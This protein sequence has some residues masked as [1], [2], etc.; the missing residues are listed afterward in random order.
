MT[1]ELDMASVLT[2]YDA[3]NHVLMDKLMKHNSVAMKPPCANRW[4]KSL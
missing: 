4:V 2:F 3:D 1:L